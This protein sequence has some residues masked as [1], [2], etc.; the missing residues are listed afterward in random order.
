M[1]QILKKAVKERILQGALD[2]FL[3]KG[4]RSASMQEIARKAGIAAGNIYNYFKSKEAVF[5]TLV[6]PVLKD[7]KAIFGIR[8]RD[9]PMLIPIDR[10]GIAEKRMDEFI[11][12]YQK[13]RKVFVLLF[14]RSGSTKFETTRT[15]VIDSLS[16]AVIRAKNTFTK[17]PATPEEEVLIKAYSVAYINGI[18][19]ILTAKIDEELKLKAL[20]RFLPFM[21]NKLIENLR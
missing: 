7:V 13:N 2:S 12:I 17:H 1:P 9:L 11:K 19:D 4:Y 3:E 18:I 6:D 16:S 8:V 15:I 21:R 5:S 14:E 10:E 20:H